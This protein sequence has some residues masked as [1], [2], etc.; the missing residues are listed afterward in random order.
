MSTKGIA[1]FM[2]LIA[3]LLAVAVLAVFGITFTSWVYL[4]FALVCLVV[5]GIVLLV[6]RGM[7]KAL[8]TARRGLKAKKD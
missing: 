5:A 8:D 6:D 2:A 3:P 7:K 1:V 4:A